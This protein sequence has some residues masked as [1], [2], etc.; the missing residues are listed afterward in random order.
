MVWVLRVGPDPAGEANPV[1]DDYPAF[2][3]QPET[4]KQY[5]AWVAYHNA[6]DR[7]L[8]AQCD[9]PAGNWSEPVEVDG[10]GQHF[11]V[12]LAGTADG[13]LWVVW[14][15]QREQN[16]DLFARPYRGDKLGGEVRLTDDP[17]PDLW[18]RMTADRRGRVWLVWQGLRGGQSDVFARCADARGNGTDPLGQTGGAWSEGGGKVRSGPRP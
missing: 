11:R 10:P 8:L 5:L 6:A 4:G 12:A 16:W 17:G 7:V 1:Q 15:A 9:G 13:T 18:H 3:I 2:W 14:S